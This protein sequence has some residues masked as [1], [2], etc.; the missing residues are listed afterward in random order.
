MTY[1]TIEVTKILPDFTQAVLKVYLK[2]T[3]LLSYRLFQIIVYEK[4]LHL[5]NNDVCH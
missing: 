3:R 4:Q 2:R 5:T 1:T